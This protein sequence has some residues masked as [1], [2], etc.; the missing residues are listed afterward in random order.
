MSSLYNHNAPKKATNL[1]VNM[2]L[3]NLAKSLNLNLSSVLETALA[4]TVKQRKREKWLE[5]NVD[6]INSYNEHI[7]EHGLFSDEVR[8]F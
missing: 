1:T 5:E 4:E 2:E 6:A 3:L 7:G 8:S